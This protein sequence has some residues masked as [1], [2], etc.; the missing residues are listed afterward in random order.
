M[1]A[2][3]GN[4]TM[5]MH[6]WFGFRTG[7]ERRPGVSLEKRRADNFADDEI[8]SEIAGID[9]WLIVFFSLLYENRSLN[10]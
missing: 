7:V 8:D 9:A 6:A 2:A 4:V 1:K 5:T 10:V 3:V